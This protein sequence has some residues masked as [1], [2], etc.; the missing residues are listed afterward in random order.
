[1]SDVPAIPALPA[2]TPPRA[3]KGRG[4]TV[5]PPNRFERHQAV[6]FDD[7]W[8]TLAA[9]LADLPP[10]PTTLIRDA[11]PLRHQLEPESRHR[12]RPGGQPLSRLRA[13]LRLLLRPADARLSRLLARPRFRNQAALQAGG[14]GAAGEGAAQARLR[15]RAA[16]ALG[17]NTDPYQPVERT[18]KLTRSVLEVLDRF[19]HPVSIVTKSAGV[20]RDLDILRIAG[21]R[22]T[23]CGSTSRSPRSTRAR[24]GAWSRAPP[25]PPRRLAGDRGAGAR[26]ACRPAC[27]RRR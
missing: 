15:R 1:M 27:W 16:L 5:N 2:A 19:N 20:L 17:S 4:A 18:L 21:E 26:R 23:W 10:L 9:D 7:G 13:R 12:L 8:D 6:A 24:A 25:R 14:R 11:S 3:R 22:A